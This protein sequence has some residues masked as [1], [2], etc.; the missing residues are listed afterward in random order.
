MTCAAWAPPA[1]AG[2]GGVSYTPTPQVTR[3]KCVRQ[4]ASHGRPRQGGT[5]RISGTGLSAVHQVTFLGGR[6]R[7]DNVRVPVRARSDRT[8]ILKVPLSAPS[9]RLSLLA[10]GT[11]LVV[12]HSAVDGYAHDPDAAGPPPSYAAVDILRVEDGRVVEHR[13][14]FQ[15]IQDSTLHDN[16]MV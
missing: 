4:C 3:V 16:P 7:S 2:N 11:C 13:D 9:G 15:E 5:I 14:V 8:L 10:G 12:L 6:G 1:L